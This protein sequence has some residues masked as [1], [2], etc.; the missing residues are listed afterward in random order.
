MNHHHLIP[1]L[2][3]LSLPVWGQSN[4]LKLSLE[5]S[6]HYSNLTNEIIDEDYKL[7]H[8]IFAKSTLAFS[9]KLGM[10]FGA[11]YLNTGNKIV[12]NI[13]GSF[14]IDE[15]KAFYNYDYIAIPAGIKYQA[16]S[17]FFNPEIA[18]GIKI[19]ATQTTIAYTTDGQKEVSERNEI[20]YGGE[21]NNITV[22]IMLT[23]GF[24]FPFNSMNFQL[25]LK[26]YYSLSQMTKNA[27]RNGHYYGMGIF[28][29]MEF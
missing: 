19:S 7:S 2:L 25:G 8:N 11:G 17:W 9:E 28:V 18:L 29:G 20:V 26:G 12:S 23:T 6:P 5:Y 24:E 3:C 27:F 14:G 22:P 13:G 4:K 21:F 1:I 10:T 15:V 16:G